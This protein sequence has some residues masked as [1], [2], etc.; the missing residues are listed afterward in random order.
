MFLLGVP[1]KVYGLIKRT[2]KNIY[3][4]VFDLRFEANKIN[5]SIH[6]ILFIC[7]GNIIRSVFSEKYFTRI[8][9][10]NNKRKIKT[11]SA[12]VKV[13]PGTPSPQNAIK[14]SEIYDIDLLSNRSVQ[15][16]E[17]MIR[18]SDLIFCM[19]VWHYKQLVKKYP[20]YKKKYFLLALFDTEI[21]N[22]PFLKY[23]IPD[24]YGME[25]KIFEETFF[26]IT[27]CLNNLNSVLS[28]K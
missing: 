2:A 16:T 20:A 1:L 25:I 10:Q 23:N 7:Q 26:R 19:E 21:Q 27:N 9:E 4:Y 5:N 18:E 11:M 13:K 8:S 22:S 17:N 6:T 14:T 15:V 3:W 12:G 28:V 24:P